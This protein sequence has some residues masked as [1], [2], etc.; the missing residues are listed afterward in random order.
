MKVHSVTVANIP[1]NLSLDFLDWPF[2]LLSIPKLKKTQM[3]FIFSL[4]SRGILKVMETF[5]KYKNLRWNVYQTVELAG[6]RWI[7]F[8]KP[9]P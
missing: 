9:E 7:F 5:P 8:L 6:W 4:N 1:V 3:H 2:P